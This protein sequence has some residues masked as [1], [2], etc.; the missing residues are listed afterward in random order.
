[1]AYFLTAK[2]SVRLIL[3]SSGVAVF[4]PAAGISSGILIALGP[5]ARWPVL[6][7]VMVATVVTHLLINDPL[8]AGVALGLSNGA[9]ALIA[10]E[11]IHYYFGAN[12]NLF[13]CATLLA[14]SRQQSPRRLCQGSGERLPTG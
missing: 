10:A 1:L 13:G 14:C 7:G 9:E 2:L 8:W 3:E 6:A 5:G 12:F 11:L 4:W